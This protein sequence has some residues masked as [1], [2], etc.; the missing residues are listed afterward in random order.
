[1]SK[2]KEYLFEREWTKD[3]WFFICTSHTRVPMIKCVEDKKFVVKNLN[4]RSVIF[5][6]VD[7]AKNFAIK[8]YKE[9]IRLESCIGIAG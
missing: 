1:M 2:I 9:I 8:M 3:G 6:K 4:K 5:T 7:K